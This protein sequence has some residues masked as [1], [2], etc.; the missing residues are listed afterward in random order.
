MAHSGTVVPTVTS[1]QEGSG[2]DPWGGGLSV[3]SASLGSSHSPNA[4]ISTDNLES[5]I[6][7]SV[8]VRLLVS[9]YLHVSAR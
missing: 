1:Q 5:P 2:F 9:I 7:V 6:N 4:F 3:Q 8:C